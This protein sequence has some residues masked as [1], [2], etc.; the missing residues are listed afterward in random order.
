M[1]TLAIS[2]CSLFLVLD[3]G[4]AADQPPVPDFTRGGKVPPKSHDWNLGPT[5]AR[6]WIYGWRSESR[7]AR[8]ILITEVSHDS[9]ASEVLQVG[10][11]IV[12]VGGK[13]FDSDARIAF[14]KAITSA[15]AKDGILPLTLWR[16]G[17]YLNTTIV[18][19]ALG[20]YGPTAPWKCPKSQAIFE[21][22]CDRLAKRIEED[23]SSGAKRKHPIQHMLN[24]LALLSSP[25]RERYMKVI[26]HE[27]EWAKQW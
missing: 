2:I 4:V 5:G 17:N 27:V 6:G 16:S 8:Q 12:G 1:K 18:L 13:K 14:A 24:A 11:V 3:Q 25:H 21:R 26:K 19:E 20:S 15:E 10:D 22:G 23:I 7:E 9:P